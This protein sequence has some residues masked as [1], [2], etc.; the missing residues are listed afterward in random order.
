MHA[1]KSIGAVAWSSIGINYEFVKRI[2]SG[3]N[4][5]LALLI[6]YCVDLIWKIAHWHEAFAHIPWWGLVLGFMIRFAVMGGIA[7]LYIYLA[8]E[9]MSQQPHF[10]APDELLRK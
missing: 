2:F 5:V 7:R 10:T 9:S 1:P 4:L 8:S 3:K 6:A